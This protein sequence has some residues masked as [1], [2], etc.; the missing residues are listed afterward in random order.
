MCSRHPDLLVLWCILF[1]GSGL[2]CVVSVA[3][4][5]GWIAVVLR[6]LSE[7]SGIYGGS[8]CTFNFC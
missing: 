8:G 6:F 4:A 1:V 3:D 2:C 7:P 5:E